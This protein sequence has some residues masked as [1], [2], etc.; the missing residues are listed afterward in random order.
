MKN[1]FL[2]LTVF[3]IST[4]CTSQTTMKTL[5]DAQKLGTNKNEFVGK[6]L[7]YL[8]NHIELD[9]KSIIPTPNKNPKE[10]NTLSLLFVDY[11]DYRNNF[12]KN[13]GNTKI[14]IR[15]NQNYELNG[16]K[17]NSKIPDC[18]KLT[19]DD[20]KNLGNLIIYDIQITGNN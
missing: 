18:T 1:L 15:F 20:E 8:L 19:K 9:I 5:E 16:D 12:S 11:E 10:I 13:N 6:P 7:S 4:S 14:T 2:L 17:C 3:L